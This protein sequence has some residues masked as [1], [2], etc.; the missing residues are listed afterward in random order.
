MDNVHTL[1]K[2]CFVDNI[3]S[4]QVFSSLGKELKVD[5]ILLQYFRAEVS[6]LSQSLPKFH[7]NFQ[8]FSDKF[9]QR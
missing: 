4:F 8:S 1:C 3:D 9:I 5:T 2:M 7:H 6:V